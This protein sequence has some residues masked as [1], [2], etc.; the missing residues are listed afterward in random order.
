MAAG[1]RST[2]EKQTLSSPERKQTSGDQPLEAR[3][4]FSDA[5]P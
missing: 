2:A 5:T 4:V 3:L 1:D